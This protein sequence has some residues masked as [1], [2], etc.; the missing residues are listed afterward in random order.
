MDR[1]VGNLITRIHASDN[2]KGSLVVTGC[3]S[4]SIAW[5]FS[6]PGSSKTLLSAY[7]PYSK[8]SL[9][10]YLGKHLTNHVSEKE[11][12]SIADVAYNNTLK[13][14][15][16]SEKDIKVF[17]IGCTGAIATNRNRKG[18]DRAHIAIKSKN[19]ECI[20]SIYFN[21]LKRDRISEEIIVSKQIIN[22]IAC[23]SE[24]PDSIPLDLLEDEKFFETN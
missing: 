21:K 5:L 17:G 8:K 23:I 22:A 11:A 9:E 6:I 24:I 15:N 19:K 14:I 20:Y 16:T 3:G 2:F 7:V 4:M 12:L 18:E 13:F 10:L 1:K